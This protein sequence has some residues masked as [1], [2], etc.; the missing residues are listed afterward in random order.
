MCLSP[1]KIYNRSESLVTN[2]PLYIEVPCGKCS[3]CQK[4]KHTDYCIR[5]F[6]Q[7]QETLIKGGYCYF[8]TLTY[9][10]SHLPKFDGI[11]CFDK[12]HI[13]KFIRDLRRQLD[14]H[15]YESKGRSGSIK[16]NFKY[17]L[18]SE[19][20]GKR[21]RPHYH[22]LFF[23]TDPSISVSQLKYYINKC[24]I[25]GITDSVSTTNDRVVRGISAI[26]YVT[27]YVTK[28]QE[29]SLLIEKRLK[30]YSILYGSDSLEYL[31]K[32]KDYKRFRPFF[33]SSTNFGSSALK[34]VDQDLLLDGRIWISDSKTSKKFVSLPLYYRRK[35]FYDVI[36]TEDGRIKW[37]MNDR[38]FDYKLKRLDTNIS[39]LED[40]YNTYYLNLDNYCSEDYFPKDYVS[41]LIL[42]YLDGRTFKD[43]ATYLY[44]YRG[45]MFSGGVLPDFHKF[46]SMSLRGSTIFSKL[47]SSN[48]SI[49][50]RMR[51]RLDKISIRETS[52]SSFRNFDKLYNLFNVLLRESHTSNQYTF[53]YKE[54]LIGK[55]KLIL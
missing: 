27:K 46:Y 49:R 26:S 48:L 30:Y 32:V 22:V 47:Y 36:K 17:F 37:V 54:D 45:K 31:E 2:G 33:N 35:L 4:Q 24:W 39:L 44:V 12:T 18:T 16:E 23:V 9:D 52:F 25:Y 43:F 19:Y 13:Q 38:G 7:Y 3:E 42:S 11:S 20:G 51:S 10:S 1:I 28:D 50:S 14:Y 8:D 55:Y 15:F 21:H 41:R 5:A 34:M 6:W 53:D 29:F 40:R